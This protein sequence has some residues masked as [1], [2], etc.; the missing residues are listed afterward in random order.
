MTI[1]LKE[2]RET[3][4]KKLADSLNR[5]YVVW[6]DAKLPPFMPRSLASAKNYN[7]INAVIL[8]QT[9]IEKGFDDPRWVVYRKSLYIKRGEKGTFLEWWNKNGEGKIQFRPVLCFNARQLFHYP[10]TEGILFRPNAGAARRVLNYMKIP[11][12]S[13]VSE[14]NMFDVASGRETSNSYFDE[15]KISKKKICLFRTEDWQTA[16]KSAV[17]KSIKEN[18]IPWNSE[19]FAN[20]EH[21][22]LLRVDLAVS[23]LTLSLGMGVP[24]MDDSLPLILWA[25]AIQQDPSEMARAAQDAQKLAN[26][27]LSIET[28]N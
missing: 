18:G 12:P 5:G 16:L 6:H 21:L 17:R 23:F 11:F 13:P 27:I 19:T 10:A 24:E 9:E 25:S 14:E 4:T 2:S 15:Y 20:K 22:H 1:T 26:K 7:G 3:F 8:M 28:D